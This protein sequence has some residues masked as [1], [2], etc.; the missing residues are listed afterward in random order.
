VAI[1]RVELLRGSGSSLYGSNSAGGV[2]NIV[3]DEGGG[4]LH[5]MIQAEGGT[6]GLGRGRGQIGGGAFNDRF[7]YTF[8]L[9]HINVSDGVDGYDPSRSTGGQAH[10]RYD[11][12]AKTSI[13]GRFY[14]SDDFV[15]SNSGPR[16]AGIPA[17]NLPASATFYRAVPLPPE[18]VEKYAQGQP[19]N[20]GN[21]TYVPNVNDSDNRR[22]QQFQTWALKFQHLFSPFASLQ[23]SYQ[24]VDTIRVYSNGPAGVGFQNAIPNYQFFA[25][26]TDTIDAK[27]NLQLGPLSQLT[28]GYEF[29]REMYDDF[30]D[31]NNP[32]ARSRTST[33]AKQNSNAVYFQNQISLFANSLQISLSGRAQFFDLSAPRFGSGISSSYSNV[34]LSAPPKALTGDAAISYF[35]QSTGTK[36]R[37]HGGNAYRAPGL[38]ERF[39]ALFS[40]NPTTGVITL[41]P[42]G[43]PYLGQD[44]YNS[45]DGGI[46]QYFLNN[47]VRI[48][49]TYFYSRMVTLTAYDSVNSVIRIGQDAWGRTQGY[50]NGSGGISR[51]LELG[52]ETR[53]TSTT[54]VSGSYT[55]TRANTDRDLQ[56]R[57][58][59]RTFHTPRHTFNMVAIQRIG[60]R[61]NLAVDFG[62]TSE[63]FNPFIGA[64]PF[65][66]DGFTK[67]DVSASYQIRPTD[68][69]GV[70]VYTRIENVFN[71]NIY[72]QGNR[73]PK[74]TIVSGLSYQF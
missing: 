70:K 37:V 43:D 1:D 67:T 23:A 63:I 10:L 59:F 35:M 39:G 33:Y 7:K 18:E 41:T 3:T 46:D 4:E 21:A 64:K 40:T 26:L 8:G 28:L 61:V 19:V 16:T 22:A 15:M 47:R 56:A 24:K 65:A 45:I 5:G 72:D 57:G 73:L 27:T 9:S 31:N 42:I 60:N 44:R 58:F 74:A 30:L 50:I 53:P 17:A 71:R 6:L 48:S 14:G 20:F 25:G 13:F 51:G 52:A 55:Y 62:G 29:E 36:L 34:P 38:Y 2:I 12:S 66:F 11:F 49:G 54:T 69:G 68:A 32:A